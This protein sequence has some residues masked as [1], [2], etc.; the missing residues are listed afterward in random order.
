VYQLGAL[1]ACARAEGAAVR[2][3]KPHGA[4]YGRVNRDAALANALAAV[5]K[6][7]VPDLDV[8]TPAQSAFATAAAQLGLDVITEGFADRGYA[9]DGTLLPR[10]QAAAV[11][12]ADAAA[13]QAVRLATLGEVCPA[14]GGSIALRAQSLCVHSDTPGALGV[15]TAV[16]DAL[17]AAGVR[18]S[19]TP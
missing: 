19:A 18:V 16:R 10:S 9:R 6:A 15:A 2:Y 3:V 7:V 17:T 11:L 13:R 12:T 4:L 14:V 8:M 5:I 1:T